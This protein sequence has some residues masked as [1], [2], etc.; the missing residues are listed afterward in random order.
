MSEF[1][2]PSSEL[3]CG[4]QRQGVAQLLRGLLLELGHGVGRRSGHD[5]ALVV[6]H[7]AVDVEAGLLGQGLAAPAAAAGTEGDPAA[8]DQDREDPASAEAAGPAHVRKASL[9]RTRAGSG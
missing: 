3:A 8:D 6:D 9:R 4:G 1:H 2:E 7:R 5:G